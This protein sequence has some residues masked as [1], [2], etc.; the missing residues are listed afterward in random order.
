[1][2]W[3]ESRLSVPSSYCTFHPASLPL[4]HVS[5]PCTSTWWLVSASLLPIKD[6]MV[7][8]GTMCE[9][10][11][12]LRYHSGL[13][14]CKKSPLTLVHYGGNANWWRTVWRFLRNLK[15][16]LSYD[17]AIPFLG[18]YLK[19][20]KNL[21]IKDTYT[22]MFIAALFTIAKIRKQPKCPSADEWIK[23]RWYTHARVRTHTHTHTHRKTS[24]P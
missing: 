23:K 5:L 17:P 24:Q 6:D 3:G 12:P 16:E 7:F 1:M 20:K 14:P 18:I 9:S 8:P 4:F 13:G 2:G 22:P 19:K 11:H 10:I 15:R 21:I